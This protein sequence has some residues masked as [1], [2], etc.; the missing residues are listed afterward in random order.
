MQVFQP[1]GEVFVRLFRLGAQQGRGMQGDQHRPAARP[2]EPLAA[3]FHDRHRP[4]QKGLRRG[5][6]QRQHGPGR[7]QAKLVFQ[8]VA[9]GGGFQLAGRLVDAPAAAD[10]AGPC[11]RLCV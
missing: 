10:E 6:T 7:D 5:G 4:T 8:P 1:A 9:A 11:Q 2:F 3:L